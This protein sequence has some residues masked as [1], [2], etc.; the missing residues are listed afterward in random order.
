MSIEEEIIKRCKADLHQGNQMI[1]K[2]ITNFFNKRA[3][4]PKGAKRS[5]EKEEKKDINPLK[6]KPAKKA[7]NKI[8]APKRTKI[9]QKLTTSTRKKTA[10][11][12]KKRKR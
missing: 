11:T 8:V 1:A 2:F 6:K 12:I 4:P 7:V 10:P 5:F 9:M 3:T